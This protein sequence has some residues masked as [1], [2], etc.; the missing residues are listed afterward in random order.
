MSDHD[1]ETL[2]PD[3][4][5]QAQPQVLTFDADATARMLSL[6]DLQKKWC[7]ARLRG[8]NKTQAA[9]EAG[10]QGDSE[11][12]RQAGFRASQ[13]GPVK[14]FLE[15]AALDGGGVADGPVDY[16]ELKRILSKHA[17]GSDKNS[18]INACNALAKIADKESE[19]ERDLA[20]NSN[21]VDVLCEI[22]DLSD[23]CFTIA[24]NLARKNNLSD[25]FETA[26][27]RYIA[28]Q[29][30]KTGAGNGATVALI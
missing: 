4:G 29:S 6:T 23:D 9:R 7:L 8:A 10:Y 14:R 21:P 15:L 3:Q 25:E 12:L 22:A 28:L 30:T 1:G 20:L 19:A 16:H 11:Q 18:A 17:R 13:S 24:L 5:E 2:E 27:Q 26:W